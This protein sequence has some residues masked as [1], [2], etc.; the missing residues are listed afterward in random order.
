MSAYTSEP[1][2]RPFP[3][4]T[5]LG[6]LLKPEFEKEIVNSLAIVGLG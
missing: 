3:G 5:N 2:E 4:V 1:D 6:K